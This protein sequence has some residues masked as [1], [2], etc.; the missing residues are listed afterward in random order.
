MRAPGAVPAG[1]AAVA[2]LVAALAAG[3]LAGCGSDG[4]PAGAATPPEPPAQRAD[5]SGRPNIVL[6]VTD[7]QTVESMRMMDRVRALIG[8]RGATFGTSYVN[9]PLCCPSRATVLTGQY[10]HNHKVLGNK[11]PIGGFEKFEAEHGDS[12]LATWLQAG[13][14]HTVHVG[15]YFNGYGDEDPRFV[16]A[17]WDEWYG[18]VNPGQRVYDYPL[19]ENGEIVTYGN[20]RDDFKEDV[21]TDHA[22]D[23][24]RRHADDPGGRP[25]YLSL[26]YTAPH[27]GGPNPSPRPPY[28]CVNAP[29]PAARYADTFDSEPLPRP[30]S[31]NEA[32]VSDKPERVARLAPLS[33]AALE[34]LTRRYRCTLE[35]LLAVDD[36]V[37]RIVTALREAGELQD[38]YLI[39]TS[40]NGLFFGEHRIPSGKVRHYEEAS[41]VPLLIR[42]PGVKRGAEIA[43]PVIN[44]DLAPTILDISGAGPGMRQDGISLLPLLEGG[45]EIRDRE[46]LLETR[47]YAGIRL[48][49]W[50]YVEPARGDPELYDLRDDPYE[51]ENLA[52]EPRQAGLIERLS[53]RLAELRDCAGADCHP[54]VRGG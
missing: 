32:D 53:A 1:V 54:E 30:P 23:A 22:V 34:Q 18:S 51:L 26:A 50:V 24:I 2:V 25:L 14:Y 8:E 7:D 46:L 13:G 27:D 20:G 42:G 49:R 37:D 15:K 28:D 31:L 16:P 5:A 21:L 39:F 48:R 45:P 6:V 4:G 44:A 41:R 19:N 38:T 17:G 9:F 29:K 36:G 43:T 11:A 40:D 12:N 33:D 3:A 52:A 10:A 47:D 35:S